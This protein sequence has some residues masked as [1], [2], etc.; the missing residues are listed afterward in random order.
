MLAEGGCVLVGRTPP[1]AEV[2]RIA[3]WLAKR[4]V[5]EALATASLAA[6]LPGA[7]AFA[8]AASGLLAVPISRLHASFLLWFRPEVVR[9]VSW[10]GDPR[11]PPAQ[12]QASGRLNPRRSFEAWAE[13]VRL[14]SAPWTA[15]EIDAAR[16]LRTAIVN[17]VLRTAEERAELTGRL[18][19]V[20][21][22]LAA[23]SYSVSH[24]LRA[25]F[26]HI[27]GYAELLRELESDKLSD[28]GRR[29]LGVITEAA[30]TAGRLVD[31]LLNFSQ[32]GRAS[33]AP[34]EFDPAALVAEVRRAME[35]D[36]ARR[37]VAWRVAAMPPV[38]GDPTMLRQVFENLLSNAVKYTRGREEA[39]IEVGCE[40]A[41][42]EFVFA[43]RD[44]GAGFDMAY[45]HKL[46]G[47][48][49]R[50]HGAEEYEGTGV[51]LAIVQ[52]IIQRHGGRVWAE[53]EPGRGATFYATL[54]LRPAE[55]PRLRTDVRNA[56]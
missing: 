11:K 26:R 3:D 9:T 27:T 21:G 15:A 56:P 50:L 32:M 10:G 41:G 33:L 45:A 19:R 55:A 16:E 1:E 53:A 52:R 49:Q 46:F 13:T 7:E 51:G 35:P 20:N 37:R 17:I 40:P 28:K 54:P 25:P 39:V 47:V 34:V 30:K 8:D 43:V 2:R 42:D 48:F 36:L 14:R 31:A 44:N 6:L 29:F 5:E 22:E 24:D 12:Q 18:E 38:R 4:G 23:F